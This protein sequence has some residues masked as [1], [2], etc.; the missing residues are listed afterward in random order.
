MAT[1]LAN[2][3]LFGTSPISKDFLIIAANGAHR[4]SFIFRMLLMSLKISA[5]LLIFI[6]RHTGLN[7]P[8]A[9]I[10][11]IFDYF[12]SVICKWATFNFEG[13]SGLL[14]IFSPRVNTNTG[15]SET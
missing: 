5:E 9:L 8:I 11:F 4:D 2:F 7:S 13:S 14:A 12:D 1:T 15:R 10:H 3:K 6:G